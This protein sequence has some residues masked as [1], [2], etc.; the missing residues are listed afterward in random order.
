MAQEHYALAMWHLCRLRY[1]SSEE[2]G[3]TH[4]L[5]YKFIGVNHFNIKRCFEQ[6]SNNP[7]LSST[8]PIL[9]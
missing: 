8:I 4:I 7:S 1:L 2:Y 5:Q 9:L 6:V 3:A